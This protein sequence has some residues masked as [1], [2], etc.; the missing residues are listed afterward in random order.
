VLS[1][2][3]IQVIAGVSGTVREAVAAYKSGVFQK[4]SK[5]TVRE[6][7][8]MGKDGGVRDSREVN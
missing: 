7:F 2:A 8:G 4:T 1:A 5:P 3:G 6:H